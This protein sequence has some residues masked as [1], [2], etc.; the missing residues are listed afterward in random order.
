MQHVSLLRIIPENFFSANGVRS[1]LQVQME[2]SSSELVSEAKLRML[3]S[4][5][6]EGGPDGWRLVKTNWAE[7]LMG[8]VEREDVTLKKCGVGTGDLLVRNPC[9]PPCWQWLCCASSVS[10][11]TFA[12]VNVCHAQ[13]FF[14]LSHPS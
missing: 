6:L 11:V 5:G 3:S 1:P 13:H 10:F 2:I 4:L 8:G 7:E 9:F 14:A 12:R